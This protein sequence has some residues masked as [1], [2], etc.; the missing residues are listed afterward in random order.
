MSVPM[1]HTL[2]VCLQKEMERY[3]LEL[4]AAEQTILYKDQQISDLK[5]EVN[6]LLCVLQQKVMGGKPD[7]LATIQVIDYRFQASL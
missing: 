7:I 6:K 4:A 3:R 5:E 1:E 2:P